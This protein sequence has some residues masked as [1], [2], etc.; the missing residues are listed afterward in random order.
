[1]AI[2]MRF[3]NQDEAQRI[4]VEAY[5]AGVIEQNEDNCAIT[6]IPNGQYKTSVDRETVVPVPIWKVI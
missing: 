6:Y 4:A 5:K 1:M 2:R 3:V